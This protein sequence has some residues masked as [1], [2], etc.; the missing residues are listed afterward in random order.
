MRLDAEAEPVLASLE[1]VREL[2]QPGGGA[3]PG[4]DHRDQ[5][6]GETERRGAGLGREEGVGGGEVQ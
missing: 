6:F 2:V 4:G 5:V 3:V 1:M